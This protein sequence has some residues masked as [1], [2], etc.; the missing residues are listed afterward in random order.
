MYYIAVP[1][2]DDSD[3][4]GENKEFLEEMAVQDVSNS[5]ELEQ[6]K[7]DTIQKRN[8]KLV[9]RKKKTQDQ[10]KDDR[11]AKQAR[12]KDQL[13]KAKERKK[14]RGRSARL[15]EPVIIGG[16]RWKKRKAPRTYIWRSS[17]GR[18]RATGA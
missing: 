3:W 14:K 8:R 2:D 1:V 10:L 13:A 17:Q 15:K 4:D 6:L 7:K 12:R 18:E 5:A 11:E 16:L 9:A